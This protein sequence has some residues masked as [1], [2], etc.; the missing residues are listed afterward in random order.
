MSR[1]PNPQN[2]RSSLL[3]LTDAGRQLLD[4][5]TPTFENEFARWLADPL[6]ARSLGPLGTTLARLRGTVEDAPCRH[7][8][9]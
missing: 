8:H 4:A 6:T 5:A 1:R 9:G 3:A 2:R 7:A